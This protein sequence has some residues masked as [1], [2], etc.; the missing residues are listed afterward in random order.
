MV[1]YIQKRYPSE[2]IG[3]AFVYCDYKEGR[4]TS[5]LIATLARQLSE[6]KLLLPQN[7]VDLYEEHSGANKCLDL[8]QLQQLLLSLCGS[9]SKAF[10]LVDALDE[11]NILAERDAFLTTIQALLNASV[12]TFI[13]SRP[14][15][16]DIKTQFDHVPQVEIVAT[17]GDIRRY[18]TG[19]VRSN[20]VFFKRISS[21][22]GLEDK[23]LDA[24]ASRA[25]GM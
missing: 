2:N 25:S 4:A 3:I 17:E 13:T 16:E 12:K 10:I 24:I 1:D 14:N 8:Q 23:I 15:L 7:L 6:R 20:H 18:L 22:P 5:E 9:F 21:T 19:K 11:C